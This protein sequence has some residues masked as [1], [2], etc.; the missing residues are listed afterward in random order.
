MHACMCVFRMQVLCVYLSMHVWIYVCLCGGVAFFPLLR[1]RSYLLSEN[2]A[3]WQVL[4]SGYATKVPT[5]SKNESSPSGA[6]CF[7]FLK[8]LLFTK[9]K[10]S[11]LSQLY[12]RTDLSEILLLT[13][14]ARL[15]ENIE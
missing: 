11:A 4:T 3:G 5:R 1:K 10:N 9:L 6:F 8:H 13:L 7:G 14:L 12:L 15:F 2:P